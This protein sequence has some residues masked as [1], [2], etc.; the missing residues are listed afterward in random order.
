MFKLILAAIL[1]TGC[2]TAVPQVKRQELRGRIVYA[3]RC[4]DGE[5]C[6]RPVKR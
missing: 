1:F 2:A 3:Y 5:E 4:M 6:D